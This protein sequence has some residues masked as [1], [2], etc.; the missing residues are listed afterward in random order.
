[1]YTPEE[2]VKAR[3]ENSIRRMLRCG[4]PFRG[5][6]HAGGY[7]IY[8]TDRVRADAGTHHAYFDKW[9]YPKARTSVQLHEKQLDALIRKL[10][11]QGQLLETVTCDGTPETLNRVFYR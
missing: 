3:Y 4:A 7:G 5:Y 10:D 9:G 8:R 11:K 2:R 6:L 1:M